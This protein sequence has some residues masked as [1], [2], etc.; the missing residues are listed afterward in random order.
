MKDMES[1]RRA[2]EIVG[3]KAS[4]KDLEDVRLECIEELRILF[5]K[6]EIDERT[7]DQ[8]LNLLFGHPAETPHSDQHPIIIKF[9][10]GEPPRAA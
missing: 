7:H 10:E 4:L 2:C 3:H 5:Q 8:C 6:E 1:L 9:P